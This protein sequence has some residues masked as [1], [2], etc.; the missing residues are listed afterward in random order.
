MKKLEL[1]SGQVRTICDAP[2]GRGGT[3]NKNDVIVF[4]PYARQ[5]GLYRV[6]AAGGTPQ[7]RYPDGPH[8]GGKRV[9]RDGRCS[10]QTGNTFCS[11]LGQLFR[12]TR[13]W[14]QFLWDPLDSK[15]TKFIV[16]AER[17]RLTQSLGFLLYVHTEIRRCLAQPFDAQEPHIEGRTGGSTFG[18]SLCPSSE[19]GCVCG[20]ERWFAVGARRWAWSGGIFPQPQWFDRSGKELGSTG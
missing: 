5:G 17:L 15:Q 9:T 2:A 18:D 13:T 6:T 11:W 19:E 12:D 20:F 16:P 1:S 7:G 10:C 3:W 4:A 14:T 8:R